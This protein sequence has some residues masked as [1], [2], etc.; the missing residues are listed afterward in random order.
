MRGRLPSNA[1]TR[2]RIGSVTQVIVFLL[3][4]GAL[5]AFISVQIVRL[6]FGE[7]YRLTAVFDDA[8]GLRSGDKVKIAGTPVGQVGE[9]EVVDGKAE[10][11]LKVETAHRVPRDSEA[12]IRWRDAVG[13]RVVYLVP[14]AD[15]EM[16]GDGDEIA[17]TRSVVDVGDL[18]N[19]LEPLARGLDPDQVNAILAAI[20]TAM[21]G[22]EDDAVALLANVERLSDT[23]DGRKQTLE[24]LIADFSTVSGVLGRRDDQIAQAVDDLA[25][26][27]EAFA[28]NRALVDDA[29]E[30]LAKTLRTTDKVAG[31]NADDLADMLGRL[32]AVM[33]GTRRN[34]GPLQGL[35]RTTGPKL[36]DM[37]DMVNEGR[38]LI[39]AV[40]CLTLAPGP[41]PYDVKLSEVPERDTGEDVSPALPDLVVGGT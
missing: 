28:D 33:D 16:L 40:P 2:L 38:F 35:M 20:Y 21:D 7:T 22:T 18:I 4:T 3:L 6:G 25:T 15:P 8:S 36:E 5:T 12:A 1:R 37:F 27:T 11:E 32:S 17:K 29:I 41:C 34:L 13:Q 14:G 24:N 23:L 9:I 31:D 30:E 10:V 26:L 19:R 39:G